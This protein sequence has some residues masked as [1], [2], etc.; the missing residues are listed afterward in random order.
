VQT[1]AE[2]EDAKVL[3]HRRLFTA[4]S[5]HLSAA[6]CHERDR[7]LATY[8]VLA[9]AWHTT[10]S[11]RAIDGARSRAEAARALDEWCTCVQRCGPREFRG[12]Y[13]VLGHW[14]EESLDYFSYRI[15]NGFA[16]GK[17][18]RIKGIIC[19]GYSYRNVAHLTQRIMLTNCSRSAAGEG[20]SPH[21]LT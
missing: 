21:L 20:Y 19:N 3:R 8:P 16:E 5:T 7:L 2:R 12:L 9:H 13:Q 10:Q 18:N 14:R 4:P 6:E 15:T 1:A 11:F 17:N